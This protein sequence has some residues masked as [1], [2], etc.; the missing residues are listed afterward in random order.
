MLSFIP[1]Q[2]RNTIA[3]EFEGKA[4]KEDMLKVD[5]EIQKRFKDKEQF[6]VYAVIHEVDGATAKALMEEAKIDI[7]HWSQYSKVAIVSDEN[8]L[9][10]MSGTSTILPGIEAKHFQMEEAE[11]AWE[12]IKS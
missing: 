7:K 8:W 3:M 2:D 4:V 12:W 5:Q 10:K 1:S 11:K 9:E 6:N